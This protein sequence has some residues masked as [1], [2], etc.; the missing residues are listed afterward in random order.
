MGDEGERDEHEGQK[1]KDGVDGGQKRG[2]EGRAGTEDGINKAVHDQAVLIAGPYTATTLLSF[3]SSAESVLVLS[4]S[5]ARLAGLLGHVPVPTDVARRVTIMYARYF[6]SPLRLTT[7]RYPATAAE[8][9]L[10]LTML[11]T[12]GGRITAMRPGLLVLHEAGE[13]GAQTTSVVC[14]ALLTI[15]R[16]LAGCRLCVADSRAEEGCWEQLGVAGVREL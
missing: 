15:S 7:S 9:C 5:R 8:M 4:G 1:S 2:M 12:G 3:L 10:V 13:Y 11:G 6:C 14:R 16:R